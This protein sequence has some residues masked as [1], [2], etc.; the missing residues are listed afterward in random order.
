M[1]KIVKN[2]QKNPIKNLIS[3][4]NIYSDLPFIKG[5]CQIKN[6]SCIF[7]KTSQLFKCKFVAVDCKYVFTP[8]S[9]E[10]NLSV[11]QNEQFLNHDSFGKN[12]PLKIIQ[13]FENKIRSTIVN[14]FVLQP[15]LFAVWGNK[16]S[17]VFSR[18]SLL[19]TAIV[20]SL[21]SNGISLNSI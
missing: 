8:S 17:Y 13:V 10:S 20:N 3:T 7:C 5:H 9:G 2:T 14:Y 19:E 15:A 18:L 21:I 16:A 12:N 1:T 6:V 11:H 4:K